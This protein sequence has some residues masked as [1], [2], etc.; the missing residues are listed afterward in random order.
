MFN[1]ETIKCT[2]TAINAAVAMIKA[3]APN[4]KVIG[5]G[6]YADV[7]GSRHSDVVYKVGNVKDNAGYLA[8]VKQLGCKKTHNPFTPNIYAVRI[9]KGRD[10]S[11]FVVAMEKL[12]KGPRGYDSRK[13]LRLVAEW[14]DGNLDENYEFS[15]TRIQSRLLG[16][17][18]TAPATLLEA[19]EII[20]TACHSTRNFDIQYDFHAGNFMY[21]GPQVVCIDPLA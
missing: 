14:F 10:D 20:K 13:A 4:M 15:I 3:Q 18:V 9:Y 7:W 21:R 5:A 1:I 16:V 6:C 12:D 2:G 19:V 17:T 8:Y 11:H